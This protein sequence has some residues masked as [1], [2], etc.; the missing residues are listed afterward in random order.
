MLSAVDILG[1]G[2]RIAARLSAYEHR[3]QQLAMATGVEQALAAGRHLVVEAGT[4]VGKS[5][6][7]LVPAILHATADQ[8]SADEKGGPR[9]AG[10]GTGSVPATSDDGEPQRRIV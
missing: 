7:Y 1:E 3:Q 8:A 6:A 5:F 10:G 2:G 9:S 4:G